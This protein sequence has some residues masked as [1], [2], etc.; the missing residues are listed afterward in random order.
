LNFYTAI[1]EKIFQ[2]EF[3]GKAGAGVRKPTGPWIWQKMELKKIPVYATLFENNDLSP[4][5]LYRIKSAVE[6]NGKMTVVVNDDC[7]GA[8]LSYL[9]FDINAGKTG[10]SVPETIE[11]ILQDY[12]AKPSKSYTEDIADKTPLHITNNGSF[13]LDQSAPKNNDLMEAKN[14]VYSFY[15]YISTYKLKEAWE[16]LSDRFK[17]RAWKNEFKDF[18]RGYVNTRQLRGIHV[19]NEKIE[20]MDQVEGLLFYEDEVEAYEAPELS[21][22]QA[23]KLDDLEYF[24]AQVNRFLQKLKE[25]SVSNPGHLPIKMLFEKSASEYVLYKCDIKEQFRDTVFSTKK[26]FTAS[27]L[28]KFHCIKQN[29]EFKISA[30]RPVKTAA[31]R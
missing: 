18:E 21:A 7:I 12:F 5:Y 24:C 23:C 17:N 20:N 29:G 15:S 6:S 19:F 8:G 2:T 11:R 13:P 26:S 14:I 16:L 10:L 27:R 9:G 25:S 4:H 30:L 1:S 28:I 22:A 31:I 3:G